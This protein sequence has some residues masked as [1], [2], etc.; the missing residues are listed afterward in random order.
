MKIRS[1]I[2]IIIS[3][4]LLTILSIFLFQSF[5]IKERIDESPQ[6]VAS[7]TNPATVPDVSQPVVEFPPTLSVK[8]P[9]SVNFAGE[10]APLDIFYV[11]EYLDRELTINTY[12]HS[13]TILLFKR[14]N[15]W[16]PVIEPILKEHNIPNDFK[17]LAIIES[18]LENVTSPAGAKGYWQ[19]L[20]K[21]A[22]EYG[23]EVNS[24]IDERYNVE[25]STIA[26]CKYLNE[27]Y[28]KYGNWTL[29]AAAYN[30]GNRRISES[31]E[32]QKVNSYYDL[33]L[34]SETARYVFR[35]LAIK[36]IF[37]NPTNFGFHIGAEDLYPPIP[38]K[39][40]KVTAT[41]KNLVEFAGQYN[42]T[43]K[44]L[45]I[46]NP[47]ILKDYLPNNSKRTYYLTIPVDGNINYPEPVAHKTDG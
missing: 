19:F 1:L 13:S 46:F 41:I 23:L 40:I 9:K 17:Y 6:P 33:L 27:S 45:K 7:K 39:K 37:E 38:V 21:T 22:R 14:A 15:R 31:L 5:S 36:T 20:K 28:E 32:E 16:F 4:F 34:N 2:Y 8:I 30:A 35:I 44:T 26:A 42:I 10:E 29:V 3:V 24:G 25:K 18:G 47:W 11:R 43:Y 12:F